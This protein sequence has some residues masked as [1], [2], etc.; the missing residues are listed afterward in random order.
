MFNYRGSFRV[1][2][3]MDKR[4]GKPAEFTFIPCRIRKGANICRHDEGTLNVYI[5]GTRAANTLLAEYPDIFKPFQIGDSEVTLLFPE[6]MLPEVI[7]I[8]RPIVK[9]K[10]ISPRSKRNIRYTEKVGV[11]MRKT[12]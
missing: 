6:L 7:E 8:L 5:P 10:G 4:T 3:E 12:G 2:Y 9:G 1:T 11:T